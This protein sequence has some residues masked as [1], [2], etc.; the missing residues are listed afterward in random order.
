MG[1]LDGQ[2]LE[3]E[4]PLQQMVLLLQWPMTPDTSMLFACCLRRLLTAIAVRP[5]T[6][7][8]LGLGA[9]E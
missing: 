1:T 2:G 7:W 5:Q 6:D 9:L 4:G 3:L 8:P